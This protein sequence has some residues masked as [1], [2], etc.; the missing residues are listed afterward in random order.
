MAKKKTVKKKTV[1]KK[2]V[3]A[4]VAKK[5]VAKKAVKKTV[6]KVAKKA[7]KKVAKK[8][9]KKTAKKAVK[10]V[11]KKAVKKVVKRTA[12]KVA[13]PVAALAPAKKKIKIK[14]PLSKKE[15]K[16]FRAVLMDKRRSLIGDMNGMESGS[17]G[18]NLQESSG[19]LS[20]APTHPADIGSD[21]FEQEFTLGLLESERVLLLE[22]DNAIGRI[23]GGT[24][25]VCLGTGKPIGKARLTARPWCK[26]GIE[27]KKMIEQGLVRP[28]EESFGD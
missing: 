6:K 28:G 18:R 22:I 26:Y 24:Y 2:A 17:L 20:N 12:V 3:K 11:A 10:K 15:L 5:A 1:A 8:A 16:K 23:D 14:S 27:Y 9:V 19:D 13:N 4:K 21:N 25:G 7:V